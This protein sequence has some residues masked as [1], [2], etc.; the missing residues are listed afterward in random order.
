MH[1]SIGGFD[2][3][4]SRVFWGKVGAETWTLSGWG[5]ELESEHVFYL[6]IWKWLK[7]KSSNSRANGSEEKIYKV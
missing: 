4:P 3:H 1:R 7:I 6:L 5:G 2:I